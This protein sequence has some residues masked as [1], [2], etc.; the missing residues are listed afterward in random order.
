M[1]LVVIFIIGGWGCLWQVTLSGDN[2]LQVE[3]KFRE[4][5]FNRCC[6]KEVVP[7]KLNVEGLLN[8]LG[9]YLFSYQVQSDFVN[10]LTPWFLNL[11]NNS[12]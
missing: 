9:T 6:T 1:N 7:Y 2:N 4:E 3:I 11:T 5:N 8:T 10:N 12:L